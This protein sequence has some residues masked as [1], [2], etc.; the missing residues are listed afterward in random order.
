MSMVTETETDKLYVVGAALLGIA[1]LAYGICMIAFRRKQYMY[2]QQ[3]ALQNQL[4]VG[5]LLEGLCFILFSYSVYN[6]SILLKVSAV[7]ASAL[8][9][10]AGLFIIFDFSVSKKKINV[11]ADIEDEINTRYSIEDKLIAKNKQLEW[12]ERTARICYFHWNIETNEMQ[13]SD[14]AEVVLGVDTQE[15][16]NFEKLKSIIIE[17][18]RLRIR[19]HLESFVNWDSATSIMFRGIVAGQLRYIQMIGEIFRDQNDARWVRGTLQDVTTQQMSVQK[20]E[21]KNETLKQI[22]WMQSHEVRGPLA[23]LLGLTE[24]IE[25]SDDI[26]AEDTKVILGGIKDASA[27]LDDIVRR[28]VKKADA[29]NIDLS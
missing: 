23:T 24:L 25:I 13:Y 3:A 22:A 15:Y 11:N 8:V 1:F 20:I 21:D 7:C 18:D 12:A 9:A 5:V 27:S 16:Q 29:A 2:K 10:W 14:G 19:R 4:P 6:N 26:N 28:I 17:E